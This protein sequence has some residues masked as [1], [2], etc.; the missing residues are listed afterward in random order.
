VTYAAVPPNE[1][2]AP[3]LDVVA[4]RLRTAADA[5]LPDPP[6]PLA[7]PSADADACL[8]A[9]VEQLSVNGDPALA[10]LVLTALAGAYPLAADVQFTL[11]ACDL[12]GP[13]GLT[14]ALL[15][16][17]QL[18]ARARGVS[19]PAR[20]VSEV[21]V[22][23][24]M[25]ARFDMHNGIQRVVREVVGYWWTTHTVALA[26]WTSHAGMLRTLVAPEQE[27]VVAWAHHAGRGRSGDDG[28]PPIVDDQTE[29]LIPWQTT[30]VLAE[31]PLPDRCPQLAALAQYSGNQV[32]LIGYDAIPVVSADLRP[33]GEPN[34]FAEYL[35]V[36]K[37]ATHVAAISSSATEEFAGF[38]DAVNSQGLR[39]PAVTEVVQPVTVPPP[40]EGY[41][42]AE[43]DVPLLVS[44]GRLEPH[45]NHSTLLHAV[46]R[47]WREGLRFDLRIVGGP[48]WT[49]E[50]VEE[51]LAALQRLGAT[52]TWMRGVGDDQLWQL[53]RD[54]SFTVFISFHEGFGLPVAES[55]ACGTP[56]LTTA[57]GSQGEIAAAGG[58]LTVDPR[59]D[60]AVADGLRR[61]L[62]D[63][64]LLGRL[65]AEAAKRP[66][67]T[68]AAY[69][70]GV[71]L[72]LV[73]GKAP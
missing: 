5:A 52:V 62:T 72:A 47:L 32:G 27:R 10:W 9:L 14:L 11:R 46:E 44:V 63:R 70:D 34:A 2:T 25:S 1:Q 50:R 58:A 35:A 55:L 31:V 42:R 37:H 67:D 65:R 45:K 4:Q 56:V 40:P 26:A 20:V 60:T 68:W 73:D 49:T 33:L 30:L 3:F 66:V 43:C 59:D 16:R 15:K 48:G 36:V 8:A 38:V 51:Q 7:K 6:T 41:V 24:D 39:G 22:D 21:V 64:E 18:R 54:A 29:L 53:I 19:R 71:W 57:Y 28:P 69:A 13:Y 12:H 61:M 23:V 17:A